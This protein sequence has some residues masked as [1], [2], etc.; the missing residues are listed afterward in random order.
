MDA[1]LISPFIDGV[2]NVLPQLGL[3]QLRR[4]N[5]VLKD[6]LTAAKEVSIL[7]GLNLDLQGNVAYAMDEAT[8][9]KAASAMM[10]GMPVAEFDAMAQSAIAEL[11]NM[12]AAHAAS[13]LEGI[14]KRVNIS[15]PTL[16]TGKGVTVRASRVKTLAV[17][18]IT[19]AGT[20][21]V[22]V[23]LET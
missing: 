10:M 12:A 18:I 13:L 16:V 15:P 7:V 19:P 20:I 6:R 8:A 23:G 14:G 17:E 21:E 5:L 9:K 22:N 3:S 11:A 2:L 1:K 4:G